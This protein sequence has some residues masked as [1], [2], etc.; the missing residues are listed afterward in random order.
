MKFKKLGKIIFILSL[1]VLL[2]APLQKIFAQSSNA[3]FAPGNIW[4]SQDSFQEGDKV[5]IYT[6]VFNPDGRQL[7]GTVIFFDNSVFL[8][9]KDFTVEPKAV[10]DVFMEW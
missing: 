5:R 3:G 7:S 6:I 2:A 1:T 10:K 9:K 8:G 4:Y